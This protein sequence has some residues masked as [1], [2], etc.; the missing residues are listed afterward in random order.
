MEYEYGG[1]ERPERE[2]IFD[3]A[4]DVYRHVFI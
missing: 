2:T 3:R 1:N 4:L